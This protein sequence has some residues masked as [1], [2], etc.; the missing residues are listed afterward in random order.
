MNPELENKYLR[1]LIQ[2]Q[3]RIGTKKNIDQLLPLLGNEISS[4]LQA[5]RTTVF[6]LDWDR[7][8]LK[9]KFAQSLENKKI[10]IKLKIGLVGLCLLTRKIINISNAYNDPRF[11]PEFDNI[12]DFRTESLLI[13]PIK[14][15]KM[16]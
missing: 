15:E 3:K 16:S 4:F 5:E 9:T 10:D 8:E 13:V 11:N 2:L 1:D 7:M 14:D 6:L 12:T